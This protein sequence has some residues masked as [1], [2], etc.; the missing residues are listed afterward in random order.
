[1]EIDRRLVHSHAVVRNADGSQAPLWHVE[2][3]QPSTTPG[4]RVPHVWLK[5]KI[6]ETSTIDLICRGLTLVCFEPFQQHG[7][8]QI[9]DR[10]LS[11]AAARYIPLEVVVLEDETHVRSVWEDRD[12]VLV[13]PDAC[14]V[15][16]SQNMCHQLPTSE[17]DVRHI[18]DVVLGFKGARGGKRC[19]TAP[20]EDDLMVVFSEKMKVLGVEDTKGGMGAAVYVCWVPS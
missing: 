17:D 16:R 6:G 12:L 5:D 14:S 19:S 4:S 1:M 13:R 7:S 15:W 3:Y 10:F 2:K 20:T 11:I 9:K 8:D 18:L